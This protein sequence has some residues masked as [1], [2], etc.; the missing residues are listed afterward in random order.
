MAHSSTARVVVSYG[1]RGV[2][3]TADGRRPFVLKGRRL[4]PVCGD[5]VEIGD[6]GNAGEALITALHERRNVLQRPDHRG[7]PE[8]LA[9]NIDTLAIVMAAEPR[10]DF[11]ITDRFVGAAELMRA[12]CLLVW[13]K[14]D[15]GF[16]EPPELEEYRELGYPLL[17]ATAVGTDAGDGVGNLRQAL[18]AGLSML[19]GQSGVGKSSLINALLPAAAIATADL[20]ESSRE[21]RHTTTASFAHRLDNDGL[22]IDSPGIRDFVPAIGSR[23]DVQH[24]FREIAAAAE[25]CRFADCLHTRE[26]DC[27]VKQALAE[28]AITP[29]RYESYKRLMNLT[30]HA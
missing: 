14:C 21:G 15:L 8:A 6:S 22:L 17:R 25:G 28:G 24:G 16:P 29:R 10:P 11:F 12:R 2:V 13:N 23:R 27:A 18:G 4:R 30:K 19:V 9:A 1:K 7:K 5:Q 3:E 20:G 26:P